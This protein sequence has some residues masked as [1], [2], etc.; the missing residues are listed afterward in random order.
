ML[1]ADQANSN[2][3]LKQTFDQSVADVSDLCRAQPGLEHHVR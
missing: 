3:L 2:M 1:G